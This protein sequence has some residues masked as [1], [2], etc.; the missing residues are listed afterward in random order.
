MAKA[1]KARPESGYNRIVA[2]IFHDRYTVDC[3]EID[4]V[5]QDLLDARDAV[6]PE[7]KRLNAGDVNYRY[8][9]RGSLPSSITNTEPSGK[10]WIII[11]AGRSKYRFLLVPQTRIVPN[12]NLKTI[13][14]PDNTPEIIRMYKLDDE[15]A[16]L[17]V[18]RYNR[19]LDIFLG[20]T[21]YS[22]QN[23]LRTFV[24]TIG[25]IEIDE[26]YIGID[27]SGCHYVIPVQAKG[28]SDQIGVAQTMQDIAYAEG[29]FP[30]MRYR[31]V[32]A[33][34][35]SDGIVA[36]FDLTVENLQVKVIEERHYRLMPAA[37]I[38]DKAVRDYRLT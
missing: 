33:Q 25:Q 31:A 14:I 27:K 35:M 38:S 19:L 24:K 12:P 29:K 6:A 11:G 9:F 20:L 7:L 32:S 26:L 13:D 22:L 10:E 36:L 5:R 34:F 2:K 28:G 15:Q 18:L 21:T 23:H 3:S 1:A 8:R 16:L 17:A 30:E 4:F 37:S